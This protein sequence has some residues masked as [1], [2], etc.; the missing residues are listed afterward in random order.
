MKPDFIT[1]TL[2]TSLWE[3]LES[4]LERGKSDLSHYLKTGDPVLDGYE[5]DIVEE[6]ERLNKGEALAAFAKQLV[7]AQHKEPWSDD[8]AEI[9]SQE[10]WNIFRAEG[11]HLTPSFWDIQRSDDHD[12]ELIRDDTDALKHV[13][14]RARDGS[15]LHRRALALH[16]TI[17]E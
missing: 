8:D 12:S 6:L 10:G 14:A 17:A 7:A 1:V 15:D 9:A 4:L 3:D 16:M 5:P 13:Y 11:S 2:T